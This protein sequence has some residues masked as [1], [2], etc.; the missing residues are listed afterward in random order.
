M[1]EQTLI[2][3]KPE[4]VKKGIIGEIITRFEKKGLQFERMKM[5]QINDE[6]AK[7]HYSHH[8]DKPFFPGLIQAITGG[9][10]VV[11][12]LSGNDVISH[13]RNLIGATD[14][15]KASPG[16]IRGDYA[17]QLPFN[18]IHASDSPENAALEIQRFFS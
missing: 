8:S 2:I 6:L 12:V 4:A 17:N 5:M 15:L 14:P 1:T 9:L 13:V 11:A 7:E 10:V 16:S 3:I 18:M